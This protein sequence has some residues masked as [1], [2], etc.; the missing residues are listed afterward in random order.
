MGQLR[1]GF[2]AAQRNRVSRSWKA[3]RNRL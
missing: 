3:G 1:H 2:V